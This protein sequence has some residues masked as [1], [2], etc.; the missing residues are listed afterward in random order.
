VTA[1]CA[2]QSHLEAE[3]KAAAA[4][5]P[6]TGSLGAGVLG[7]TSGSHVVGDGSAFA[8]KW[9]RM[10]QAESADMLESPV[11]GVD[12]GELYRIGV[13]SVA[14][15][16]SFHVH[17][18]LVR[19]HVQARLHSL[20]SADGSGSGSA[21]DWA[22]AEA[23]AFGSLQV[24]GHAIRLSGQDAQR[25]TFS[26][27]HAVLVDQVCEVHCA[28]PWAGGCI[29]RLTFA[30]PHHPAAAPLL[31]RRRWMDRPTLPSTT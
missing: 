20:G 6:A 15:P 2:L 18:R 8:G 1:L 29:I 10:R 25:G 12:I 31:P 13:A 30:P 21:V 23:L 11:T 26:H 22:T 3:F 28:L 19:S 24:E 16:A 9:H 17:E 27:R 4:F 14:L 5:T 7:S